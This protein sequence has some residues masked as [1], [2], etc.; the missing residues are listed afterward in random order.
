VEVV[1]VFGEEVLAEGV[2]LLLLQLDDQLHRELHPLAHQLV[3]GLVG[4]RRV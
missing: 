4:H 1:E 2:G 3:E